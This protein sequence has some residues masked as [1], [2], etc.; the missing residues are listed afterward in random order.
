LDV[1]PLPAGRIHELGFSPD[2]RRLAFTMYTPNLP[3][4]VYVFDL[5]SGDLIRWTIGD[6]DD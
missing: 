5:E 1:P 4:E 6:R 2:G 3:G